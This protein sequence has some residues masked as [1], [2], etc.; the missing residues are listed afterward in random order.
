MID[1][2]TARRPDALTILVTNLDRGGAETQ[3]VC[4]ALGLRSRGWRVRMVSLLTPRDF[5]AHLTDAGIPVIDL[6]L[7]GVSSLPGALCRLWRE[8]RRHRPDVLSTFTYHAN[9]SGKMIGRLAG[10]PRVISSIRSE[11][12]GGRLRDRLESVTGRLATVTTTNSRLVGD[13]LVERGVVDVRKLAVVPNAVARAS[14]VSPDERAGLRREMGAEDDAP[15]WLA[16][17]RFEEAKDYPNLL[18]AFSRLTDTHPRS[19]LAIIGYGALEKAIRASV[20]EAGPEERVRVLGR[21]DD[22]TR[23]LAACDAYVL[24]SAW[25]GLPN[26]VL[27]AMAAA[28]PV[29][30]TAVGGV[31]ELVDE[32]RS[33]LLVPPRN[34][35]VLADAMARVVE[36]SPAEW[37]AM[38]RCGREIV[39][40]RYG[41]ESILDMWEAVL[42]GD[43]GGDHD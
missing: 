35:P 40:T 2:R 8:L 17:G 13:R 39:E 23:Y 41:V 5:V 4:L 30:A 7:N 37:D 22:A 33:G 15:L 24:S 21:H 18:K 10:V 1:G 42:R 43:G 16:V 3:A 28:K 6:R 26:T 11:Y 36:M 29:V 12:F 31:P 25:E 19:R 32:G 20:A 34:S 9:V 27:E 38:G 14:E